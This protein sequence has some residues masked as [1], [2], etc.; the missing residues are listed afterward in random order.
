MLSLIPFLP[1]VGFLVNATVGRRM[2][3]NGPPYLTDGQIL[4]LRRWITVGAPR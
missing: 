2:P 4:I 1:F 3:N